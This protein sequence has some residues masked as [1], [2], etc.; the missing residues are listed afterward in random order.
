MERYFVGVPGLKVIAP[1]NAYDAKGILKS[2]I[3]DGGVWWGN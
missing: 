1:S 3:R 2:A